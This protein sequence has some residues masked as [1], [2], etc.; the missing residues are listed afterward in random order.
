MRIVLDTSTLIA[1]VRSSVGASKAIVD[2]ALAREFTLLMNYPIACEYRTVA[3][4]PSH[5]MASR[6]SP[7]Q[8]ERLIQD[9]EDIAEPVKN[10][11]TYRPLSPD[12]NDDLVLEL[13]INGRA[14]IIVTNDLKHLHQP[15]SRFH[16]QVLNPGT[17]LSTIR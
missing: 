14:D 13:A 10:I 5:V 15:A 9:L 8:I 2:L 1:A 17:A 16:I 7:A 3:L 12:P 4:R 11:T 6:F